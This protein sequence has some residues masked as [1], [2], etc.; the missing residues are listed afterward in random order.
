MQNF[1]LKIFYSFIY[2]INI[3]ENIFN[4]KKFIDELRHLKSDFTIL[5]TGISFNEYEVAKNII[6]Y[7]TFSQLDV[8]IKSHYY[9]VDEK[10]TVYCDKKVVEDFLIRDIESN[11]LWEKLSAGIFSKI[12]FPEGITPL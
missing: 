11:S 4:I 10:L 8:L 3:G 2:S 7:G 5:Q 9:V 1:I 12:A 6:K